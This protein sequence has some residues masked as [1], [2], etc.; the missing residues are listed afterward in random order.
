M[1]IQNHTKIFIGGINELKNY[2][3][4]NELLI[5]KIKKP[6]SI[7]LLIKKIKQID[8]KFINNK[9]NKIPLIIF[10]VIDLWDDPLKII[11]NLLINPTFHLQIWLL[12]INPELYKYILYNY[13]P[14]NIINIINKYYKIECGCWSKWSIYCQEHLPLFN[15]YSI[16]PYIDLYKWNFSDD[17]KN[18]QELCYECG[19]FHGKYSKWIPICK[20][21]YF[22]SSVK[23]MFN[24][25][26]GIMRNLCDNNLNNELLIKYLSKN[27][28]NLIDFFATL[29]IIDNYPFIEYNL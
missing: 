23:S 19:S 3:N 26:H 1:V 21:Q 12:R 5:Y 10:N 25:F 14:N 9:P 15:I 27:G 8:N 4:N 28:I 20:N 22:N 6:S 11:E 24:I 18:P 17:P 29:E 7:D 16:Q 13:L 2:I